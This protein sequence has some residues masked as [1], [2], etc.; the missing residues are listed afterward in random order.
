MRCLFLLCYCESLL[1]RGG[2]MRGREWNR[3]A[4]D[5]KDGRQGSQWSDR[6]GLRART[7]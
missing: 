4:I 3:V 1:K 6:S 5:E 7:D 2:D